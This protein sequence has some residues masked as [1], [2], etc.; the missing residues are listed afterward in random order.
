MPS[1][2]PFLT[3]H[4]VTETLDKDLYSLKFHFRSGWENERVKR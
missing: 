1:N 4:K 3:S 2:L